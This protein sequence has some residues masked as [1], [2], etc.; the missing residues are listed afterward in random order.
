MDLINLL[1]L[2]TVLMASFAFVNIRYLKLP[3]TIGLMIVS[4]FVSFVVIVIGHFEQ[5]V[6][7]Y[8]KNIVDDIDF[9]KVLFDFMLSFLLFAGSSHTDFSTLKENRF[10]ILMLA[11]VG[12]VI[13]T[14]FIGS[15]AYLVFS[16]MMGLG[17]DYM[18][19]LIFGALIS[20]TDPIAVLGILA[21][22]NVPKKIEITI[23]GESLFNDGVGVVIFVLLLNI[24]HVGIEK[25]EAS[26]VAWLVI[27][28]VIGGLALGFLLGW[29]TYELLRRIDHYQTEVMITLAVVMGGYLLA[30][31]L[32]VSG[33]LAMVVAGLFTGSIV[34]KEA[35]SQTTRDYVHKFWEMI[36]VLL[37]AV[38]FLIMGFEIIII[39]FDW[40]YLY[41][42]VMVIPIMLLGRYLAIT[43]PKPFFRRR[44]NTD[45][46]T[47]F[48]LTWGG[49]RGGISIAMALSLAGIP[50]YQFIVFVTYALVMFSII[51][52]GLTI[53]RFVRKYFAEKKQISIEQQEL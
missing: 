50:N 14:I 8:V 5:G 31:K 28:E 27:R 19:C 6:Y 35:M 20:P 12:V 29:I 44:L 48:V 25:I 38:L 41:A 37:N 23:V 45:I 33:P 15:L 46:R 53:E 16:Q 52:Q 13:S 22:A 26:D 32:H 42:S 2:L 21:R 17:I 9:S 34:K 43:L 3:E 7:D 51:G 24:I 11:T 47:D 30:R 18:Y 10:Q 49:L 1:T 39:Q 4:I 40:H 36:D